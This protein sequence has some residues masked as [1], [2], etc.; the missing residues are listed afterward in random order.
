MLSL[1]CRLPLI[2]DSDK[3]R[4]TGRE[5]EQPHMLERA[6]LK[7]CLHAEVDQAYDGVIVGAGIGGLVAGVLLSGAG[8]KVLVLDQ[9]PQPGGCTTCFVRKGFRFDV[10]LHYVGEAGPQG[11]LRRIFDACGLE[12]LSF[13][14]VARDLEEIRFPDFSITVPGSR[15]GF[16]LQLL[17]DFP[18]EQGGIEKYFRFLEEVEKV[19]RAMM[20]GSRWRALRALAGSP[21]FI[22]HLRGTAEQ[23]VCRCT[24]NP[25][26]R[27]VLMARSGTYGVAPR[28]VSAVL[29]GGLN[30]HYL[31]SGS[32]FPQGGGQELSDRLA[33]QI[34]DAGSH[35][36]LRCR[37]SSI[38]VKRKRARGVFFTSPSL[39]SRYVGANWVISNADLKT[40]VRDLIGEK[41]FPNRFASR[42]GG[43]EMARPMFSAYLGL[44]L[45]NEALG[46]PTGNCWLMNGTD[47][48]AEYDAIRRG[49][50]ADSPNIYVSV[51]SVKEG[52]GG[53]AAPPGSSTMELLA[54][55]PPAPHFWGV[56]EEEVASGAYSRVPA[57][58]E[59]K[60]AV[61]ERCIDTAERL[62]PN[63]RRHILHRSAATP[64]TLRRFVMSTDGSAYGFSST[65]GQFFNRRPGVRS[66]VKGLYFCGANTRTGHGIIGAS[67]SGLEVAD[68][69]LG[70]HLAQRTLAGS[71]N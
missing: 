21:S 28:E 39:G 2:P 19:S 23:L 42:I 43:F 54:V 14:R 47:V 22:R 52:P 18:E 30:N 16:R 63:L 24:D 38:E 3:R 5:L 10:G 1:F 6:R 29:Y 4:A 71:S 45:P 34:L 61:L 70:Q 57:Y 62:I 8:R 37:V 66:P 25:R 41:H 50:M 7:D 48:N 35:L 68:A 9:G 58:R 40:T 26:L 36:R 51:G 44:D 32:W 64:L 67:L 13:K 17:R 69:L 12:D 11:R 46:C 20:S 15:E 65:P 33:R 31:E 56:T 49:Q 53:D 55:A 60:E 27:A 59:K